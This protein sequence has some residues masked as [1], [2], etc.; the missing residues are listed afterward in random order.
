[1]LADRQH[2]KLAAE[3]MNVTASA[4]S[5]MISRLEEQMGVRLFD[6]DTRRVSL[7]PEGAL[8]IPSARAIAR[9]ID[10]MFATLRDHA[11]MRQGKVSL[12]ALPSLCADWLPKVIA[13]YSRKYPNI[14]V[15]LFD[16]VAES[17]VDFVR[18]GLADFAI[19]SRLENPDEF[20]S[21]LLFNE[22]FYFV[23][24]PTH[25]LAKKRSVRLR[26]LSGSTYIQSSVTGS[27][28]RWIEPHARGIEFKHTGLEVA[29]L[30]TLAGLIHNGL[31]VSI[32]PAF[33]LFQFFRLGLCAIPIRDPGLHRPLLLVKQHGRSLSVAAEELLKTIAQFP[34]D[35]RY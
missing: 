30:S 31:G 20:E 35:K 15:R 4:F 22:R 32:V 28:W 1:M 17:N 33:G 18:R 11:E 3:Q 14:R 27:I 13:E 10:S 9:D 2:F 21:R 29:R 26:D 19:N 5:Q 7:T 12:A 25:K 16:T 6:R 8:L 23:C 34:P 24:P